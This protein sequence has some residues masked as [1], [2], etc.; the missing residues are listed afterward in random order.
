M[1]FSH[2]GSFGLFA[3]RQHRA[4]YFPH[5]LPNAELSSVLILSEQTK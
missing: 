4:R 5:F 2:R 3:L 1:F